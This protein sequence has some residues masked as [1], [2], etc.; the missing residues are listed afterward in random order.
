MFGKDCFLVSCYNEKGCRVI[1]D[2]DL[3]KSKSASFDKQVQFVVKRKYGVKVNPGKDQELQC[4][5]Q[6]GVLNS[7]YVNYSNKSHP[8]KHL[9]NLVPRILAFLI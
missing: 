1:P 9:H 8:K 4:T 7:I 6:E 2:E 5:D 3:R